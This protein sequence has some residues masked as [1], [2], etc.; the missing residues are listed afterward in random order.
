[1]ITKIDSIKNLGFI[2]TS[3]GLNRL[4]YLILIQK[5]LFMAGTI[6]AK[7]HCQI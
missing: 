5:I 1:M 3:N 4:A 2:R 7:Q 6:Q